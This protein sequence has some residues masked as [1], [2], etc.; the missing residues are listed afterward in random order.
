[1]A[2][3]RIGGAVVELAGA[4]G[5]DVYARNPF[6]IYVRNNTS[7]IQPNSTSQILRRSQFADVV[8][9]YQTLTKSQ[10]LAWSNLAKNQILHNRL[11]QSYTPSG[12]QLFMSLNMNLRLIGAPMNTNPP[13]IKPLKTKSVNSIRY[14]S[15]TNQLLLNTSNIG[16]Q[17]AYAILEATEPLNNSVNF[18]RNQFRQ[19]AVGVVYYLNITNFDLTP[20]YTAVFSTALPLA[21]GKKISFR[22]RLII[23]ASGV[24]TKFHFI[25]FS[26]V[27]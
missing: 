6:G 7:P 19:I 22:G 16:S 26:I 25:P 9:L 21:S 3:A 27:P 13:V 24:S 17:P 5:S 11:G 23:V 14:K 12:Y 8:D 15:S 18:V 1:M 2:L 10:Y 20:A 4:V